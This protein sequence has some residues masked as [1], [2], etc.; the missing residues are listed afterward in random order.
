LFYRSRGILLEVLRYFALQPTYNYLAKMIANNNYTLTGF[1]Q[2]SDPRK[3]TI[4][5]RGTTEA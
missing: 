4:R 2:W 1:R 5:L 3:V